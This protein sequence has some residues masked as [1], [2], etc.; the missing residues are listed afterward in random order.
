MSPYKKT[1]HG[2]FNTVAISRFLV[3]VR[4]SGNSKFFCVGC[5]LNEDIISKIIFT[6]PAS[7]YQKTSD[8]VCMQAFLG[9][10]YLQ[11]VLHKTL[12]NLRRWIL[13]RI[14]VPAGLYQPNTLSHRALTTYFM[15]WVNCFQ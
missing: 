11:E 4:R 14:E 15:T 13:L 9:I 3:E 5:I 12:R 2:G 8:L 7:L 10:T 6:L 1:R